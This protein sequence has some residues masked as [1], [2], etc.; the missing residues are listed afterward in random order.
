[1]RYGV[2]ADRPSGMW[3]TLVVMAVLSR[4]DARCVRKLARAP[5]R[6]PTASHLFHCR[7]GQGS[8][9]RFG[10]HPVVDTGGACRCWRS[11]G[12]HVGELVYRRRGNRRV[13]GHTGVPD[14][15]E[16]RGVGCM[17]GNAAIERA[18]EQGLTVAPLCPF[19]RRWLERHPEV[20]ARVTIE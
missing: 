10:T 5:A 11:I 15:R 20:S 12:G 3:L 8:R 16:G 14:G 1:M 18:G 17:L 13:L 4:S 19:A 6:I 7:S 2:T 9:D